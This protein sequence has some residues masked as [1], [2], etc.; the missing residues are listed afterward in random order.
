MV[1]KAKSGHVEFR[2]Y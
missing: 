1:I 2:L